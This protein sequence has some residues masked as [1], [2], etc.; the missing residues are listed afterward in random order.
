[1]ASWFILLPPEGAARQVA[2]SLLNAFKQKLPEKS[3]HY[4]D[5]KKYYSGFNTMLK[6]PEENMIVDLLN[7]SL[8][9]QCIQYEITHIL[10][11]ALCPVTLFTLTLIKKQKI[12]SIHW[13]VEDYRR[14]NYWKDILPGYSWF[15]AVQKG[16]IQEECRKNNCQF[17]YLPTAP[18]DESLKFKRLDTN[19]NKK[20]DIVFV[21]FPTPYRIE[22]L[23]YLLSQSFSLTIDGEGWDGYSGPLSDSIITGKWIDPQQAVQIMGSAS[24]AINL[25]YAKPS[26]DLYDIQLSPRVYDI[27]AMG[28]A[29]LSEDV[30]LLHETVGDC[31]YYTFKNKEDAAGKIHQ[32][33]SDLDKENI[34]NKIENNRSIILQNHTWEKRAEQIIELCS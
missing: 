11:P 26:G 34:K 33:I 3:L 13:F 22:F 14:A 29:L 10:V 32:I 17:A 6:N 27:L 2:T 30:P 24:I 8:I 18:S 12:T 19:L 23:E 31:H 9:V 7:Q 20:T 4:F 1:M 28:T 25:S 21:G 15:L 16:F 5:C